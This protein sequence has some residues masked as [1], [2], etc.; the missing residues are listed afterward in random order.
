M[1]ALED[2]LVSASILTLLL[3]NGKYLLI[4]DGGSV[5]VGCVLPPVGE[6]GSNGS[7][8]IG[9]AL[10]TTQ[11]SPMIQQPRVYRSSIGSARTTTLFGSD[12]VY[13]PHGA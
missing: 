6:G 2:K 11:I 7:K 5:R 10:S 13:D 3:R 9:S 4:T 1:K 8:H 12:H